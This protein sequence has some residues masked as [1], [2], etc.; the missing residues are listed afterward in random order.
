MTGPGSADIDALYWGSPSNDEPSATIDV[1]TSTPVTSPYKY[2]V[3][4]ATVGSGDQEWVEIPVAQ[5]DP[6]SIDVADYGPELTLSDVQYFISP[7]Q[8]PLEEL[9]DG[10]VPPPDSPWQSVPG[11]PNGTHL[12][13]MT[14]VQSAPLPE[15]PR[16]VGLLSLGGMGLIVMAWRRR[17]NAIRA[18]N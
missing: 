2:I 1:S 14:G 17:G 10:Y 4:N 18:S 5:S 3:I 13:S 16:I 6:P 15:P 7:T 12:D 8:I 9:N 11:I